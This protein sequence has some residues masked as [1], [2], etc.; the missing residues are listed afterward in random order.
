MTEILNVSTGRSN[1]TEN[2]LAQHMLNGAFASGFSLKLMDKDVAMARDLATAVGVPAPTLDLISTV[3]G[4]ALGALGDKAD[5]TEVYR[6]TEE[7]SKKGS[8]REKRA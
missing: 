4:D 5:H 8:E 3:L 6:Y 1:T 7:L 2:K